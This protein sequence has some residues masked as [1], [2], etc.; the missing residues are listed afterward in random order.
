VDAN[1]SHTDIGSNRTFAFSVVGVPSLI[2][3]YNLNGKVD[4]GDYTV[5]RNSLGQNV[6]NFSGADGNG[7]G[8]IDKKDYKQW[9]SQYGNMGAGSGAGGESSVLA[10]TTAAEP[11]SATP[12]AL[13]LA[14]GDFATTPTA[15]RAAGV[16]AA[17]ALRIARGTAAS[18]D[19]LTLLA[20]RRS[21]SAGPE[22]Q[23]EAAEHRRDEFGNDDFF[24]ALGTKPLGRTP[25]GAHLGHAV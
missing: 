16:R 21:T 2:G 10:A 13:D 4:H 18:V 14:L 8:V 25:A 12:A 15:L 9:K 24:A 23:D 3:D 20:R 19:L 7:D 6:A 17:N 11:V 5:W 1:N 22:Q